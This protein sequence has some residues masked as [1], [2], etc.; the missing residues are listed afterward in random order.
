MLHHA[1]G[2]LDSVIFLV[3]PGNLRSQ[4]TVERIGARSST[5]SGATVRGSPVCS[6][7]SPP[8]TGIPGRGHR[9]SLNTRLTDPFG[10]AR[11]EVR[12][13]TLSPLGNG[14]VRLNGSLDT[15]GAATVTAAPDPLCHPRHDPA[16][17]RTPLNDEPTRWSICTPAAGDRLAAAYANVPR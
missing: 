1:F 9:T 12:G 8:P 15:S 5:V 7:A 6:T 14:Q 3:A 10:T 11:T 4:R 2:A 13:F 16:E 17:A